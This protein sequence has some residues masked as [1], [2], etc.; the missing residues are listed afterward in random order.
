MTTQHRTEEEM[1]GFK[2]PD[3]IQP[4]FA[5]LVG[6]A[7]SS[8]GL[9]E[10]ELRTRSPRVASSQGDCSD[11]H[12]NQMLAALESQYLVRRRRCHGHLLDPSW[13]GLERGHVL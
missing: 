13:L 11:L 12:G 4:L 6:C 2:I 3:V 9:P 5:G 10:R 7:E 8:G 1:L